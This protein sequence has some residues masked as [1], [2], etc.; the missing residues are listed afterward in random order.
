MNVEPKLPPR[1]CAI[2]LTWVALL[3]WCTGPVVAYAPV[4]NTVYRHAMTRT[5]STSPNATVREERAM[6]RTVEEHKNMIAGLLN[7]FGYWGKQKIAGSWV[8]RKVSPIR[9]MRLASDKEKSA[10]KLLEDFDVDEVE[11]H[12]FRS[13]AFASWSSIFTK[14]FPDDPDLSA[15]L[16]V[17]A[18]VKHDEEKF[19]DSI[20]DAKPFSKA[21]ATAK[22]LES[23]LIDKWLSNPDEDLMDVL[24]KPLLQQW[25]HTLSKDDPA[26][27]TLF[28]KALA[29]KGSGLQ[30]TKFKAA[31]EK[32]GG[33][34]NDMAESILKVKH[35]KDKF[36]ELE[37]DK[38]ASSRAILA[39][40]N[41]KT[42][43]E[44]VEKLEWDLVKLLLPNLKAVSDD[45]DIL[46][47]CVS[48]NYLP[49]NLRGKLQDAVFDQ[50]VDVSGS[51]ALKILGLD[52]ASDNLFSA[53]ILP[54]ATYMKRLYPTTASTEMF[55]TLKGFYKENLDE[56]INRATASGDERIRALAQDLAGAAKKLD[57]SNDLPQPDLPP[58]VA[59]L[60]EV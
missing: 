23:K 11:S 40:K 25:F 38:E 43:L 9:H 57:D 8:M 48:K 41:F 3:A 31:A 51:T 33:V 44:E 4:P 16:M 2:L 50:W 36:H 47:D 45:K 32:A 34:V 59:P 15:K 53:L 1:R 21:T 37:L 58:P 10:L 14:A 13:A 12:L 29:T 22:P 19:I 20:A 27:E 55:K 6:A 56:K 52:A 17:S 18:L 30:A 26:R 46:R 35:A 5:S 24:K 54:W 60:P 7:K 39:N 28:Y 42:W 49:D